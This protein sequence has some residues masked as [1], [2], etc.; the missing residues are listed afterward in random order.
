MPRPSSSPPPPPEHP[1]L[2]N[3]PSENRKCNPT[4]EYADEESEVL[5]GGVVHRKRAGRSLQGAVVMTWQ[6]WV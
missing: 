6:R 2:L 5:R 3:A 1:R 4:P